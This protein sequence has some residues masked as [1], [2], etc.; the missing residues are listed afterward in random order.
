MLCQIQ[1]MLQ[2]AEAA[3]LMAGKNG[4]P[5]RLHM[6]TNACFEPITSRCV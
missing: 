5:T 1:V 4:R 3:G 6:L 2:R